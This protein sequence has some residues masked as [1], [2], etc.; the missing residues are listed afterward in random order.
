MSANQE[1]AHR[2]HRSIG[3]LDKFLSRRGGF[4]CAANRCDVLAIE[5]DDHVRISLLRRK[6]PASSL[7]NLVVPHD[8]AIMLLVSRQAPHCRNK[9]FPLRQRIKMESGV[10][11]I[12]ASLPSHLGAMHTEAACTCERVDPCYTGYISGNDQ[13]TFRKLPAS[14]SIAYNACFNSSRARGSG[15]RYAAIEAA[16]EFLERDWEF[17]MGNWE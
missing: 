7:A 16:K 14:T 17:D 13:E 8:I 9:N 10:A 5:H 4:R 12:P 2:Q 6:T 11:S 15:C 3:C 1:S